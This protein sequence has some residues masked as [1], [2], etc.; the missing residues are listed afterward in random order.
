MCNCW[1]YWATER[2]R[3][4]DK[5]QGGA[6]VHSPHAP[7]DLTNL[8]KLAAVPGQS[9]ALQPQSVL[10]RPDSDTIAALLRFPGDLSGPRMHL[11][12]SWPSKD[13]KSHSGQKAL[14]YMEQP[15]ENYETNDKAREAATNVILAFFERQQN[16]AALSQAP[17]RQAD[18]ASNSRYKVE[19]SRQR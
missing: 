8:G 16:N 6:I 9:G 1:G 12:S 15:V 3:A 14:R 10:S 13:D 5:P 18:P 11:E 2:L 7:R 17:T 4:L 19:C